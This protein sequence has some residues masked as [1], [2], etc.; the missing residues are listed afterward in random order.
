[1][2]KI[3][4][5]ASY[6]KSGNTWMR[7]F[8]H[9]LINAG[10]EPLSINSLDEFIVSESAARLYRQFT[11]TPPVELDPRKLAALRPGVHRAL[12]GNGAQNV[13]VKTHAFLGRS[14]DVPTITPE[15]TA[16]AIYIVRNP[17]DICISLASHIGKPLDEAIDFMGKEMAGKASADKVME[18]WHSWSTNVFSWAKAPQGGVKVIRYED[19]LENSAET[20]GEAVR[21]LRLD[22][23]ESR[24]RKAIQFSSFDAMRKQEEQEPFKERPPHNPRFFRKGISGEWRNTLTKKQ[25][26]RLVED[27]YEPMKLF[28]YLPD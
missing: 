18:F 6:P 8:L 21:F 9:N 10:D 7:S 22:V 20:F 16:G 25:V 14:F 4:W 23:S 13:Y 19:L 11:D 26:D 1:M 12:A 3:I 24:I 5:I 15:V 27:H 2:G 17:L 28:G